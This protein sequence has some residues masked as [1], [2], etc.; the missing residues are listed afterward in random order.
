MR[1][2]NSLL[3]YLVFG[4]LISQLKFL[5]RIFFSTLIATLMAVYLS[6]RFFIISISFDGWFSYYIPCKRCEI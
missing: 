6:F 3:L 2:L 5:V 1:K 4:S